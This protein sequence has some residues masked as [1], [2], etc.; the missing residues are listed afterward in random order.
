M[1]FRHHQ[2][3]ATGTVTSAGGRTPFFQP[4]GKQTMIRKKLLLAVLIPLFSLG[5][6]CSSDE[7]DDVTI[8][9]GG[10]GGGHR[11]E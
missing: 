7:G 11:S 2:A 10:G 1:R 6:G 9:V 8:N 3:S 5:V 4:I